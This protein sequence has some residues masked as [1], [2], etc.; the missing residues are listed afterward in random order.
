MGALQFE[1]PDSGYVFI[2]DSYVFLKGESTSQVSKVNFLFWND[3][4]LTKRLHRQNRELSYAIHWLPQMSA[5]CIPVVHLSK[6]RLTL[7][8][9]LSKLHALFRSHLFSHSS[10]FSVPRSSLGY[11][12]AFGHMIFRWWISRIS[13]RINFSFSCLYFLLFVFTPDLTF[14][15]SFFLWQQIKG[16]FWVR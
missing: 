9:L 14:S 10:P 6:L 5:S 13:E 7:V 11:C 15:G 16:P 4:A 3:F 12:S 8:T 2:I 1:K